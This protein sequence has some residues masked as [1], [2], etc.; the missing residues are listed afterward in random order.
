MNHNISPVLTNFLQRVSRQFLV[1]ILSLGIVMSIAS[2][3]VFYLFS[4]LTNVTAI[5]CVLPGTISTTL[6]VT[7]LAND[8]IID[9]SGQDI[10]VAS[11]GNLVIK[12]HITND[13]SSSNDKGI[14]IKVANL[15]VDAGGKVSADGQGYSSTSNDTNGNAADAAG[16]TAGSGG[17]HGGAG[18][19]GITDGVNASATPGVAFGFNEQPITLGGAGGNS[20]NAGVGGNGGGALKVEASGTVTIN[21]EV[22]ANGENGQKSADGKSSGGGGAGGSVWIEATTFAGTGRVDARGGGADATALRQ[23]GGGGGGRIVMIC[24]SGNTFSGAVSVL[25]GD[26]GQD[27]QNGT[28]IGPACRPETPTIVHIYEDATSNEIA[29]GGVTRQT[30]I[31]FVADLQDPNPSAQVR[32]QIELRDKNEAFTGIFTHTQGTFQSNPQLCAAPPSDCGQMTV[33]S[34]PVSK[35]YKFRIRAINNS[36]IPGH[37][38]DFGGNG[39]NDRDFLIVGNPSAIVKVSGDNQTGTAGSALSQS[40]IAKVQDS[41][42]FGVPGETIVWAVTAGNGSVLP[43]T[44][45]TNENGLG[46]VAWTL[47]QIAGSNNNT[48]T[49]TRNSIGTVTFTASADAGELHHYG[50][51]VPDIA[52]IN[53]NF[54]VT[55]RSYD[56][57]N[58]LVSFSG[59]VALTPVLADNVTPGSGTL[60]PPS[61]NLVNGEGQTTT[62]QYTFGEVMKIKATDGNS[63]TGVSKSITF[64]SEIGSCPDI[65]VDTNQTW[66]AIDVPGGV[67][68]CRGLGTLYVRNGATLTLRG[69]DSLDANYANDF[70]TT[71]LADAF[72]V[73]DGGVISAD[74]QGY[75]QNGGPGYGSNSE[76]G[77]SHG[78]YGINAANGPYGSVQEPATLGS[79]GQGGNYFG[80]TSDGGTGGGAIRLISTATITVNGTISANGGPGVKGFPSLGTGAGG[81]IWLSGTSLN[82]DGLI[83][84]N[85]GVNQDSNGGSGGRIAVYQSNTGTFPLGNKANMQAFG[86]GSSTIGG[87]GT[88]YI[89]ADGDTGGNGDLYVNN[90][91]NNTNSAGIPFDPD[92][93]LQ[94]FNKIYVKEYGHLRVLGIGS[95][96]KIAN[97]DGLE[98]DNTTSKVEPEGMLDIPE[99]FTVDRINLNIIGD[100]IGATTLTVGNGTHPAVMTL[101]ART[102][103]RQSNHFPNHDHYSFSTITVKSQ[104]EFALVSYDGNSSVTTDNNAV[105]LDDYG[106]SITVSG[107]FDVQSGGKVS[108]DGRGYNTNTGPGYGGNGEAGG[109]HGG[110]GVS[111]V[112]LPYGS[113]KNP[114]T[115]GSGGQD[116]NYYGNISTGGRGG[117]A[118]KII[119][120]GDLV[121][122]G[123]ITSRG[124][125]GVKG[126]PGLGTGAGG[127]LWII[128]D[129][130][131]GNGLLNVNGGSNDGAS[132][133]SGG[134]IAIYENTRGDYPI[135]DRTKV[136]AFG[137]GVSNWGG[138]G[139]IYIDNDGQSGGN[140][141]LWVNNDGKNTNSAGIPYDDANPIQEFTKIHVK[142]YGHLRVMGI[143][144]TLRIL[145]EDGID[146]DNTVSK[147]EP[148]GTLQVPYVFTV[149]R[150]NLNILGELSG[151][152][153]LT[154]GN[155][156]NPAI[157]TLYARTQKRQNLHAPNQDNYQFTSV[158]VKNQGQF[159][160]TSYVGN[161]S[162]PEDNN[163][164]NLNEYGVTLNV[165]DDFTIE[166]GGLVSADGRGYAINSGP[167]YGGNGEGGAS[168]GGYGYN[169]V[170]APYGR[171]KEPVTLGSGGNNGNYYGNI[172]DGGTGGGA[173]KLNI[174]G[175]LTVNGGLTARGGNGVKGFPGLGTGAGGS[176]WVVANSINGNGL[177][178]TNGGSNDGGSGGSGGRIAIYESI[179]GSFP[180]TTKSNIQSF[181]GGISN[182]GGPGTIYIDDDGQ[183][184]GNGH[185]WV[186][187]NGQ[188][189]N[190]AAIPYDAV[191]PV[192]E[193]TQIHVR[194]YGHLRVMGIDSTLK[195]TSESGLEGDATVSKI[196]PEGLLDLPEIFTV[197]RV[198]L[199]VLGDITGAD[200][201]T[202]GN[203]T[204]PA[205]VT[206]YARTQKRQNDRFPN[207][208]VYEFESL[209]V[210]SQATMTLVS[211]VGN[212]GTP[213][214]NNEQNANEYGVTLTI[215][216][217]LQIDA[218]GVIHADGRGFG[219]NS[220]PGYGGNGEAGGSHGG[221]GVS[222]VGAPYGS[223]KTPVTLGSGGQNG[224]Y[225][226][227]ISD[228]GTGGG[229]I[230][231]A[232]S[233]IL[234]NNGRISANGGNGVKGF[235]GLGTGAGGSIWISANTLN[236]NGLI[237]ANGGE[238][239]GANGGSGG[240]IA[241]YENLRGNF[242][243]ESKTNLQSFGGGVNNWG[244]PGTVYIDGDGAIGGNGDLR[245]NNNNRNTL[246][247][248]VPYNVLDPVQEFSKIYVKEYGHLRVMGIDSTLKITSEEGLEGDNTASRVEP[249]G[250]LELPEAFTID[251]INLTILGDISGGNNLTV[252][253][254]QNPASL[255]MY[256][257]TQKRQNTRYPNQDIY[258]FDSFTVKQQSTVILNSYDGSAATEGDNNS[259]GLDDYGVTINVNGDVTVESSAKIHADGTGYGINTGPGYGGNGEAGGSHGG[260][261][262]STAGT[263]YGSIKQPVTLGSGGQNGNYFG[264]ISQGGTGGGAIKIAATGIFTNN[265]VVSANGGNGVKG[266]PGL[267]TGA[268]GSL[269]IAANTINGTGSFTVNGGQNSGAKGGSGGH[270]ALYEIVRGSFPVT[271]DSNVQSLGG[272]VSNWGGPGTV[273]TEA[274]NLHGA[275]Q[276]NFRVVNANRAGRVQD[277]E[278]GEWT[279]HD[280]TLGQNVTM[281][282]KS[283][284][285][286]LASNAPSLTPS[287][288]AATEN[289][290][291][292]WHLDEVTGTGAYLLDSS[293]Y[294]R[295]ATPVKEPLPETG[296]FSN[297]YN[298]NATQKVIT[299]PEVPTT[300]DYTIELWATFPLPTTPDGYRTLVAKN[301][302]TYHHILVNGDGILGAYFSSF[303]SSGFDVD[304]LAAGWHHIATV[305]QGSQTHFYV[306]GNK[307]GTINTKTT[308]PIS[309]IGGYS[310]TAGNQFAGKLDEIH[311]QNRALTAR[312]IEAHARGLT[313]EQFEQL[314][315]YMVGQGVALNLS[316]DFT[317]DTGA[318]INGSGRGFPSSKGAGKGRI[319]VGQT[320]GSGGAHGGDGGTAESDGINT[321]PGGGI[322]YGDQYRP[323]TLGSGG[324]ASNLGA[325]GGNGGNAFAVLANQGAITVKGSILMNGTGGATGSPGG[326]GG[327][328][329]SILLYGDSCDIGGTLS[330]MGG[331]G[332]DG[333]FDGGGGGGGRISILFA[334]G[335]CEVS[336]S[337]SV[338]F[339]AGASAQEGQ[340]GTY[341]PEPNSVP[342]PPDFENQYAPVSPGSSSELIRRDKATQVFAQQFRQPV[343]E[344]PVMSEGSVL[345]AGEEVIPVGGVIG[346]TTVTLKANAYDAGASP[347]SPKSLRLE[348]ELKE[349]NQSFDGVTNVHTSN[350]I[351]FTGGAPQLLSATI[352]NLEVGTSYKW[353][354]RTVN[355]S[356][357]LFSDWKSFGNNADSES[358]FTISSTVA[359][360]LIPSKTNLLT[361]EVI[362][363]T[364]IARDQNN[365]VDTTY[366]GEVTFSSTS[367]TAD[368][369]DNYTFTVGDNGQKVFQNVLFYEAGNFTITVEDVH[370]PALTDTAAFTVA[371]PSVPNLTFTSSDYFVAQNQV[372][373]LQWT[374]Q[375]M[376]NLIIDNGIGSVPANGTVN[377]SIPQT[378]SFM[379]QGTRPDDSIV[380]MTITIT[381]NNSETPLPTPTPTEFVINPL[382]SGTPIPTPTMTPFP[383]IPPNAMCPVIQEFK[384]SDSFA[385]PDER[386]VLSWKV[387]DAT[388]VAIDTIGSEVAP[389]GLYGFVA[390]R[391][392]QFTI[393]AVGENCQKTQTVSLFFVGFTPQDLSAGVVGAIIVAETVL[394]ILGGAAQGNIW[395]A[396]VGLIE[397][398]RRRIPWGVVYD[399]V[400][401]KPLGRAII[402]LFDAGSGKI[403][404]TAVT[405]AQGVFKLTPKAGKY[406]IQVTKI[407]YVFPSAIVPGETD[408]AFMNVYH[409]ETLEIK[410]DNAPV[411]LTIPIDPEKTEDKAKLTWR[412]VKTR[413]LF[414]FE[415]LNSALLYGG[416]A[417]SIWAT[418][419][420]PS[421]V[422]M[423]VLTFYGGFFALKAYLLRIPDFGTVSKGV[424]QPVAGVEVGLY[425]TEFQTLVTRTFTDKSGKYAFYVPN[426]DYFIRLIDATYKMTNTKATNEKLYVNAEKDSAIRI[427]RENISVKQLKSS[428]VSASG[429]KALK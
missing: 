23:G 69:Y 263:A 236:G 210:K 317:L 271:S 332:G 407:G 33:A 145:D 94:E 198:N 79:G 169:G 73:E 101:Y 348:F 261:G 190:S 76:A 12:S 298:F 34:V 297:G 350:T 239:S 171:V 223:V 331:N 47:G 295:H 272:G 151:A 148:E 134:R 345:G 359:I 400:T 268:G 2:I 90:N 129:T 26:A 132:G 205:A 393:K 390:D 111:A 92:K 112:G 328:G 37:W 104:G 370:T 29:V 218:N 362:E 254:G 48:M 175:T 55:V 118:V 389:N 326:G 140:G 58:N 19:E 292:L 385:T 349:V 167:G 421:F 28:L 280:V 50:V 187:N 273:Y 247:A 262:I 219:I 241:I 97:E 252:G 240:R 178:T 100:Y 376:T 364:V 396:G 119:T 60:S 77:G 220:G 416:F 420:T 173:I 306:D 277:M 333:T 409:G 422:N 355:V 394:P 229:A 45:I 109:S 314:E 279:F 107:N 225:F 71:V 7:P 201:L 406:F 341:P 64:V 163:E 57:F 35:E 288:P 353:R 86:G 275:G 329:G 36:G 424:L 321:A 166:T 246:S 122:N 230:R 403:V 189:T 87:P 72:E 147:I 120:G 139:T 250:M 91:G 428:K 303:Y 259:Q 320:G 377:V 336:G 357:G 155:G 200:N 40:V 1:R 346:G 115:M 195:I 342:L 293:S 429:T 361:G 88:I 44:T 255:T 130:I 142:E 260:Y 85:G 66:N 153:S 61:V 305:A 10:T 181:G 113:V 410:A 75:G 125:N 283:D 46:T 197:D 180:I 106:V 402:R 419:I 427:V 365:N 80:N 159:Y 310:S 360:E 17:G 315:P 4:A 408:D 214:D 96:L 340:I 274:L 123:E 352:T 6:E 176:L 105:N 158:L 301:G 286:V 156:T 251:R 31:K 235:P 93:P 369:P 150:V 114:L 51:T 318:V 323:L 222:A 309:I 126:F 282:I 304:S 316:G 335:P 399:G 199:T 387:I 351:V 204:N 302:G 84:A 264:N 337:I 289:S 228:G 3:S 256:A 296:K 395:L 378:M 330:A 270:L 383:T 136:T 102:Q 98:G 128:A 284:T 267:G 32:L 24:E 135:T 18:G 213:N 5:S 117:G 358:D 224:N 398:L 183:S 265:G 354:V 22:S 137:G 392:Q 59:N 381:V 324:G 161:N 16:D 164:A 131:N 27:G 54:T 212:T 182:W 405:D 133:G 248:A 281:W 242:P 311:I 21:G 83:R 103:K 291:A 411:T 397:R 43:S 211:Y 116:G 202:I 194:E 238:N 343:Y 174:T 154:I 426:R 322:K 65:D 146:G 423:V 227:N 20:G 14:V 287:A 168:H 49:A 52:V 82:G 367:L 334:S 179:R 234:Q 319:G 78:G 170:G 257:R 160:L 110:Y 15:T 401:K 95:T 217:N 384:L 278:A 191:N 417:Y 233:G 70:S 124:G 185:L 192:Q 63:N 404:T 382:P 9:C 206:L 232:V 74:G 231:L 325:I 41:A 414:V 253:N 269:W 11:G 356:N 208:D 152:D 193:F 25:G 339:G 285:T 307:V 68:D 203:E 412:L 276:G 207:Q 366:R 121:V 216:E 62:A 258:T 56:E 299:F 99:T 215:A 371:I 138:P 243:I 186:N 344:T 374:S 53:E 249:E 391:S 368:L 184:G 266:F 380:T 143:D 347:G 379:I 312:E 67:F 313:L 144:S 300:T 165:L 327:A 39:T 375:F 13:T 8:N 149:D 196:E 386:V 89:D 373:T 177:I 209:H 388:S 413:A 418:F 425:E 415:K 308:Q 372:I 172:S 338:A 226:G 245:V 363:L 188:N 141:E 30:S 237:A 127:S 81:S 38:V 162:V 42:G 108:A 244:G 294:G 157:V 290:L 221:F